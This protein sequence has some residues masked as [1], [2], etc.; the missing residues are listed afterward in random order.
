MKIH[1]NESSLELLREAKEFGLLDTQSTLSCIDCNIVF[2]KEYE[3]CPQCQR[4]P[5]ME[6]W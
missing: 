3:K 4:V 2:P 6:N 5:I 1:E